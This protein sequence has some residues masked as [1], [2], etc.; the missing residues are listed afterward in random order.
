MLGCALLREDKEAFAIVRVSSD[1]VRDLDFANDAT[2]VLSS[3]AH[4]I[5]HGELTHA[6]KKSLVSLLGEIIFFLIDVPNTADDPLQY[7][8]GSDLPSRARQK[9]LREQEI[10]DQV[11]Q[12]YAF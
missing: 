9:L 4:K 2:R 8:V 10:I 11:G 12:D 5:E 6:H 7:D 3:M 1:E